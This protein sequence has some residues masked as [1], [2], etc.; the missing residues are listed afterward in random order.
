VI[1]FS[2]DPRERAS[3]EFRNVLS[4]TMIVGGAR[5]INKA[6]TYEAYACNSFFIRKEY[7][8]DG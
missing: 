8:Y 2:I 5:F 1:Q 3:T 4:L 6:L 7:E